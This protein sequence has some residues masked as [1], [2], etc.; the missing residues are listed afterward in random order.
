MLD[1]TAHENMKL[2]GL[3]QIF[4]GR[5]LCLNVRG[6]DLENHSSHWP[7]IITTRLL[8]PNS[9]LIN[10]FPLYLN[11]FRFKNLDFAN[12]INNITLQRRQITALFPHLHVGNDK[13]VIRYFHIPIHPVYPLPPTPKKRISHIKH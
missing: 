1:I 4:M 9:G 3:F 8:W 10:G 11:I 7:Y 13:H 5:S 6:T 12:K 2:R